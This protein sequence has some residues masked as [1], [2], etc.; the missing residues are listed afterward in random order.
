MKLV[1]LWKT[2]QKLTLSF[3]LFPPRTP[4]AAE[5]LDKTIDSLADLKPDFVS[6]AFGAG[7]S[8]REGSHQLIDKLAKEKGLEVL[9]YFAGFGLS[10]AEITSVLD[11]HKTLGVDNIGSLGISGVER[12]QPHLESFSYASETM[13][14]VK[15]RYDFAFNIRQ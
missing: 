5:N 6:V 2:S 7:G 9:G 10:L 15:P 13:A 3:K 4:T 11:S 1:D 8:T 14:F 12:W